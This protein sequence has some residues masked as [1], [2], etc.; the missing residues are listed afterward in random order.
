MGS[1]VLLIISSA[2]AVFFGFNI[3]N[4][5]G[6]ELDVI[7]FVESI[8]FF[9]VFT[10][11]TFY[12]MNKVLMRTRVF[13]FVSSWLAKISYSVYLFHIPTLYIFLNQEV[14][15]PDWIFIFYVFALSLFCSVFYFFVEK[16]MLAA[17]P[18]YG[19]RNTDPSA[20]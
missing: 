11:S 16:P 1:F 10:V 20:R 4:N 19:A 5:T 3:L 8:S 12:S 2:V 14:I 18:G 6:S 7:Y 17:R 13:D 15:G 9:G